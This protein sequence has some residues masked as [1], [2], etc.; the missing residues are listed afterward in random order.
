M[1][2]VT[3]PVQYLM[4]RATAL[5]TSDIFTT[6]A[7]DRTFQATVTGSGA[8]SATIIIEGAN[9]G[10][11]FLEIGTITLAGDDR[12]SDGFASQ[13]KWAQVRARLSTLSGT[14]AAVTVAMGT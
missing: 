11:D 8:L 3:S 10:V 14:D 5:A 12:V 2:S 7:L 6:A 4:Q 13:A 9:N 1:R